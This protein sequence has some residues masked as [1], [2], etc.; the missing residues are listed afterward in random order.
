[1]LSLVSHFPLARSQHWRGSE[2]TIPFF[3]RVIVQPF[4]FKLLETSAH[5]NFDIIFDT[6]E[7][8]TRTTKKRKTFSD[9]AKMQNAKSAPVA[10]DFNDTCFHWDGVGA[11]MNGARHHFVQQKRYLFKKN[12]FKLRHLGSL[13]IDL[14]EFFFFL[15]SVK[16]LFYYCSSVFVCDLI[17]FLLLFHYDDRKKQ[18]QFAI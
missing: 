15:L 12:N 7:Q 3:L 17:C 16:F 5:I 14:V 8:Q 4:K 18:K 11:T 6:R 13:N 2:L 10:N 9:A 1:M